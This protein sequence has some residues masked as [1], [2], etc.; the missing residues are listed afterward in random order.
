MGT[1]Y[2]FFTARHVHAVH[3]HAVHARA[4]HGHV[5]HGHVMQATSIAA[6]QLNCFKFSTTVKVG[7]LLKIYSIMLTTAKE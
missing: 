5:M 1:K 3:A 2:C 4:Y 6:C 7:M